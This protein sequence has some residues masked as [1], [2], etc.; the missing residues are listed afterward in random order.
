MYLAKNLQRCVRDAK[1]HGRDLRGERQENAGTQPIGH[2]MRGTRD[3]TSGVS[4]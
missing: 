3:K 4:E 2:E 1:G